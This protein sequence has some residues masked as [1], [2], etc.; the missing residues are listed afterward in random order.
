MG[1]NVVHAYGAFVQSLVIGLT[2]HLRRAH[3]DHKLQY[4]VK[5]NGKKQRI[6]HLGNKAA[7]GTSDRALHPKPM[8]MK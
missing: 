7:T 4:R 6:L 8:P 2:I 3:R 1:Q 5:A